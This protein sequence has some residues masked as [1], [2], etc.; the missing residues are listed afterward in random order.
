[1]SRAGISSGGATGVT[2]F[3]GRTVIRLIYRDA[4]R[5]Y[6]CDIRARGVHCDTVYVPE[7]GPRVDAPRAFDRAAARALNVATGHDTVSYDDVDFTDDS[8]IVRS[9]RP[10]P[11]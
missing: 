11:Q 7:G 5:D 3:C 1:M 10:R 4:T 6:K 2:R 8:F 9:H